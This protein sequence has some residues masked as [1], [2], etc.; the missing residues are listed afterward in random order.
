MAQNSIQFILSVFFGGF[1]V[2][3]QTTSPVTVPTQEF[4]LP[5][6]TTIERGGDLRIS[7]H[8]KIAITVYDVPDLDGNHQVDNSGRIKMPL[9]GEVLVEG[10]T[11]LELS[12]EIETRLAVDYLQN[13]D[14]SV[15]IL[16]SVGEQITVEGS[17]NR[18]GIYDKDGRLTLLQAVALAGGESE[19]ADINSVLVVRQVQGERQAALFDLK[20]VRRGASQDPL[21]YGND[22]IVVDG[23]GA[24]KAYREFIRFAPIA[25][26]FRAF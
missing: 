11:S 1:V 17:V 20:Q 22:I 5:D 8:D 18:P 4:T 15:L 7:K 14:V 16:D 19:F 6:S 9:I 26:F 23:D 24:K 21:I 10:F 25:A 3:C 13:P 2:A 12:K